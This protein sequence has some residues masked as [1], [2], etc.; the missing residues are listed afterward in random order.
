MVTKHKKTP[1]PYINKGREFTRV[2]TLIDVLYIHPLFTVNA[3][4][5]SIPTLFDMDPWECLSLDRP[6]KM[7]SANDIFSLS[8]WF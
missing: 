5:T 4:K 2:A 7:L 1:V 8:G 6:V 3:C